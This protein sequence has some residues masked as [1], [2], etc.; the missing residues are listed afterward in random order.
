MVKIF[1]ISVEIMYTSKCRIIQFSKGEFCMQKS[2][3]I[4]KI[5]LKVGIVLALIA[6]IFGM[7]LISSSSRAYASEETTTSIEEVVDTSEHGSTEEIT[8]ATDPTNPIID[9]D[10]TFIEAEPFA[11]NG[12]AGNP[13]QLKSAGNLA[14]LANQ[15]NG[16]NDYEGVYFT[17][18]ANIDLAGKIWTP[19]G[20]NTSNTFR[21][22]FDGDGYTI[23]NLY[24]DYRTITGADA[25]GLFGFLGNRATIK[26]VQVTS[27]NIVSN[28]ESGIIAGY[29]N[30]NGVIIEACYATGTINSTTYM[31]GIVGR[32]NSRS[33]PAISRCYTNVT[34]LGN[35]TKYAIIGYYGDVD[36]CLADAS[37]NLT[38]SNASVSNSIR[39]SGNYLYTNNSTS[40]TQYYNLTSVNYNFKND[41]RTSNPIWYSSS[42]S[43]S[44]LCLRGVGNVYVETESYIATQ[45]YDDSGTNSTTDSSNRP[46]NNSYNANGAY[47]TYA[48]G[49]IRIGSSIEYTK[50]YTLGRPIASARLVPERYAT[51]VSY[52]ISNYNKI[53]TQVTKEVNKI[54][55]S[56]SIRTLNATTITNSSS[57]ASSSRQ[58]YFVIDAVFDNK[59]YQFTLN[60]YDA[61]PN[62]KLGTADCIGAYKQN[63]N[64]TPT[65]YNRLGIT[66]IN[67]QINI[68]NSATTLGSKKLYRRGAATVLQG[69]GGYKYYGTI[70][71]LRYGDTEPYIEV[72]TSDSNIYLA[73]FNDNIYKPNNEVEINLNYSLSYDNKDK[74]LE[75]IPTST[76]VDSNVTVNMYFT[77]ATKL[78]F[79]KGDELSNN[80]VTVNT[81][82][83]YSYWIINNSDKQVYTLKKKTLAGI[84]NCSFSHADL[85]TV[86]YDSLGDRYELLGWADDRTIGLFTDPDANGSY[87]ALDGTVE[88]VFASHSKSRLNAEFVPVKTFVAPGRTG[89]SAGTNHMVLDLYTVFQANNGKL[90]VRF[91]DGTSQITSNSKLTSMGL[92]F[93]VSVDNGANFTSPTKTNGTITL[94]IPYGTALQYRLNYNCGSSDKYES[95]YEYFFGTSNGSY[96]AS[97]TA[98]RTLTPFNTEEY[99][100]FKFSTQPR[101]LDVEIIGEDGEDIAESILSSF[102]FMV[103]NQTTNTTLQT[104]NY[105][106]GSYGGINYSYSTGVNYADILQIIVQ[107]VPEGYHIESVTLANGSDITSN[108]TTYTTGQLK[109]NTK[110]LIT[111]ARNKATINIQQTGFYSNY[112]STSL[113]NYSYVVTR[114]EGGTNSSTL[115]T[116]TTITIKTGDDFSLSSNFDSSTAYFL[117]RVTAESILSSLNATITQ[118]NGYTNS[119][120]DLVVGSDG[121]TITIT[122]SY[123]IKEF[124]L[125]F[126][127]TADS[128]TNSSYWAFSYTIN[129][130]ARN[131][132]ESATLTGEVSPEGSV[133]L[134]HGDTIKVSVN[135]KNSAAVTS[136]GVSANATQSSTSGFTSSVDVSYSSL[137]SGAK[138]VFARVLLNEYDVIFNLSP[139]GST[140]PD[141][142][143]LLNPATWADGASGNTKT[144][145][146]YYNSTLS[147]IPDARRN[148]YNFLGWAT[149]ENAT[150][151]NFNSNTRIL[152]ETNLYPV[153]GKYSY[154]IDYDLNDDEV[155]GVVWATSSTTSIGSGDSYTFPTLT[156]DSHD[157]V[158]WRY[159]YN[160]QEVVAAPGTVITWDFAQNM[161][162]TAVWQR[163]VFDVQVVIYGQYSPDGTTFTYSKI[164]DGTSTDVYYGEL[165]ADAVNLV[166]NKPSAQGYSFVGY[167]LNEPSASTIGDISTTLPDIIV[168][169]N[170][171]TDRVLTV[172]VVYKNFYTLTYTSAGNGDIEIDNY[173][174]PFYATYGEDYEFILTPDAGYL[175]GYFNVT[176]SAY[177]SY[178]SS[179]NV[180]TMPASDLT[181][182]AVFIVA[183][184]D[185]TYLADHDGST[186]AKF[187]DGTLE[188]TGV[189]T[190]LNTNYRY[191]SNTGMPV[192]SRTGYD[193]AGWTDDINWEN[194]PVSQ[195]KIYTETTPWD[196]TE[197]TILYATWE[198]ESYDLIFVLNASG[199]TNPTSL[200]EITV[201]SNGETITRTPTSGTGFVI[202]YGETLILPDL[203]SDSHDLV[204]W[205]I[206]TNTQKIYTPGEQY[207]WNELNGNT[208]TAVWEAK[209]FEVRVEIYGEHLNSDR[210]SYSYV[211]IGNGNTYSNLSFGTFLSNTFGVDALGAP[212]LAINKPT[213]A[214]YTF[215]GYALSVPTTGNIVPTFPEIEL[216]DSN[217]YVNNRV[218]TLYLVYK[219]HYTLSYAPNSSA[220]GSVHVNLS[221]TNIYGSSVEVTVGEGVIIVPTANNGYH[222]VEY[223]ATP[224]VEFL[225]NAIYMPANN[226]SIVAVFEPDII[227]I[228]YYRNDGTE[229]IET[230][231]K[232]TFNARDYTYGVTD[233]SGMPTPVRDGY[234]FVGW[235]DAKENGN[236]YD[237]NTVWDIYNSPAALYAHWSVKQYNITVNIYGEKVDSADKTNLSNYELADVASISISDGDNTAYSE[238]YTYTVSYDFG[239]T[240]TISGVANAGFEFYTAITNST[241][242]TLPYEFV[243]TSSGAIVNLYYSRQDFTL[244]LD[245]NTT[246]NVTGL[247]STQYVLNYGQSLALPTLNRTGYQFLDFDLDSSAEQGEF[248][249]SYVQG[250]E[251][252]TLYAIWKPIDCDITIKFMFENLDGEFKAL[253]LLGNFDLAYNTTNMQTLTEF[254]GKIAYRT[255]VTISNIVIEAGFEIS[256]VSFNSVTLTSVSGAYSFDVP[257]N[258]GDVVIYASRIP[259]DLTLDLN[260]NDSTDVD[261][262]DWHFEDDISETT[263]LFGHTISLPDFT[264]YRDGY[265]FL[266]WS[267]GENTYG[268]GDSYTQGLTT[269]NLTAVWDAKTYYITYD[270][271]T[272]NPYNDNKD[273]VNDAWAGEAGVTSIKSGESYTFPAL[274]SDSHDFLGWTITLDDGTTYNYNVGDTNPIVWGYASDVTLKAKWSTKIFEVKV[275][276]WHANISAS[277]RDNISYTKQA[278]LT[279]Y[280]Q[281][282]YYGDLVRGISDVIYSQTGYSF[283]GYFTQNVSWT[284]SDKFAID[285]PITGDTTI[286][287]LYKNFYELNFSS[288]DP[289]RGSLQARIGIENLVSG[290]YVTYGESVTLTPVP[291]I[292][293]GHTESGY[294]FSSYTITP[295]AR[296]TDNTFTM[297]VGDTNG[298]VSVIVNFRAK[299]INITYNANT[300][301]FSNGNTTSSGTVTYLNTNYTF[302]EVPTKVGHDFIEWNTE[303]DGSG[304][305]YPVGANS[306]VI[307]IPWNEPY[308][309]DT[310]YAI[311]EPTPYTITVQIKTESLSLTED[312]KYEVSQDATFDIRYNGEF[313]T[314]L[315]AF[316][317]DIAYNTEVRIEEVSVDTGFSFSR[318]TLNDRELVAIDGYYLFNV[319][320]G[321]ST[322][323]IYVNRLPYDLTLNADTSDTITNVTGWNF[324]LQDGV[325]K[326]TNTY[327]YKSNIVLP[328]PVREGYQFTGWE[329]V[330]GTTYQGGE[331][332]E[333]TGDVTL[334]ATWQIKTFPVTVVLQAF[335]GTNLDLSVVGFTL[336]DASGPVLASDG[337]ETS[338]TTGR[339]FN[340]G[341]ELTLDVEH[342]S[343][344]IASITGIDSLQAVS[345]QTF[346]VADSENIIVI[347]FAA[348]NNFSIM[349]N[350]SGANSWNFGSESE[351]IWTISEDK[352]SATRPIST[353]EEIN[354]ITPN[355]IGYKFLGWS[356]KLNGSV[357]YTSTTYEPTDSSNTAFSLYAV[358]EVI[359]Y[360]VTIYY[361]HENTSE[362]FK[363]SGKDF[364]VFINGVA[365]T[366]NGGTITGTYNFDTEFVFTLKGLKLPDGFKFKDITIKNLE[367]NSETTVLELPYSFKVPNY[368][369]QIIIRI[370]R[371]VFNVNLNP[372]ANGDSVTGLE[373]QFTAKYGIAKTL[374]IPTRSGY[375]FDGWTLDQVSTTYVKTHTQ[376]LNE[377]TYYAQWTRTEFKL[378]IKLFINR[379]QYTGSDWTIGYEDIYTPTFENGVYTFGI[380]YNTYVQ[381]TVIRNAF[382]LE[383]VVVGTQEFTS[384]NVDFNMPASDTDFNIYLVNENYT[385]T[386]NASNYID[387]NAEVEFSN[388]TGWTVNNE[389]ASKA[390]ISYEEVDLLTPVSTGYDFLGWYTEPYGQGEPIK[391]VTF[392]QDVWENVTYYA[393]WDYGS[394]TL[395]YST[396]LEN[397]HNSEFTQISEGTTEYN[398]VFKSLTFSHEGSVGF[399]TNVTVTFEL[400]DGYRALEGDITGGNS[401]TLIDNGNNTYTYTFNMPSASTEIRLNI[402]R[403]VYTLTFDNG[404]GNEVDIVSNMP[405]PVQLKLDENCT[406]PVT[407]ER[408]GYTFAG[409][410]TELKGQGTGYDNTN[411]L[412]YQGKGDETLYAYWTINDSGLT[413]KKYLDGEPTTSGGTFTVGGQTV[414]P[415][416]AYEYIFNVTYGD[417]L[418]L[419]IDPTIYNLE[420]VVADNAT[421]SGSGNTRYFSVGEDPVTIYIYF[422][423]KDYTLTL[424]ANNYLDSNATVTFNASSGWVAVNSSATYQIKS[425]G[426]VTLITPSSTGYKFLGW[427]SSPNGQGDMLYSDGAEFT[428]NTTENVTLYAKWEIG[429]YSL[430]TNINTQNIIDDEFANN[431][432]G[433]SSLRLEKF[434]DGIWVDATSETSFDYNT[435]LRYI[436]ETKAGFN[437]QANSFDGIS[438]AFSSNGTA[439]IY[440]FTMAGSETTIDVNI[441]R[442]EYVL[443]FANGNRDVTDITSTMPEQITLKFGESVNLPE[444]LTAT[445]YTFEEWNTVANGSGTAYQPLANFTQTSESV[446]LYAVWTINSHK[447]TINITGNA[448]VSEVS[449]VL[450]NS[451]GDEL[452][453]SDRVNSS[454]EVSDIDYNSNLT[455]T[456]DSGIYNIGSVT[457]TNGEGNVRTFTMPDEDVV[458]NIIFGEASYELT[459][460][461]DTTII[462]NYTVTWIEDEIQN[463]QETETNSIK[464]TVVSNQTLQTLPTPSIKGLEFLGWYTEANG[465]G[466]LVTAYTQETAQNVTLYAHY[467]LDSFNFNLNISTEDAILDEYDEN[468]DGVNGEVSLY[469]YDE[470]TKTWLKSDAFT[471]G[472]AVKIEYLKNARFEFTLNSGFEI[473][474]NAISGNIQ[475]VLSN[476]GNTYYYTFI[477]TNEAVSVNINISRIRYTLEFDKNTQDTVTNLPER[478][479]LKMGATYEIPDASTMVRKGYA[480]TGIWNIYGTDGEIITSLEAGDIFTQTSAGNTILF[481][482]WNAKTYTI[483]FD[484]NGGTSSETGREIGYDT[485]IIMPDTEYEGYEL[486]GWTIKVKGSNTT[487]AITTG[488]TLRTLETK[489]S[490]DLVGT[491]DT[492]TFVIT[493]N[494]N[495]GNNFIT[496]SSGLDETLYTQ[497][498]LTIASR[499]T[500]PQI[501][502][503]VNNEL[504]QNYS[505]STGD[506]VRLQA[507]LPE[508]YQVK[509]WQIT[510]TASQTNPDGNLN[511]VEITG[512]T[513]NLSVKLVYEPKEFTVT[514]SASTNGTLSFAQENSGVY[515]ITE[516][517]AKTLSG[518]NVNV[519]AKPNDGF[520]F[521]SVSSDNSA[522]TLSPTKQGDNAEILVVGMLED[523]QISA[524]FTE[525]PNLVLI[526]GDNIAS[527]R[528]QISDSTQFGDN[529]ILYSDNS[530]ITILTGQYLKL[531]ITTNQGYS[532]VNLLCNDNNVVINYPYEQNNNQALI[533]GIIAD[534]T[535][536]IDTE[537]NEYSFEAGIVNNGQEGTIN[538]ETQPNISGK[539][540][541]NTE[542]TLSATSEQVGGLD[543]YNFIGWFTDLEGLNFY[544]AE[545]P[546][547][548]TLT[549]DTTL[550]AKFEIKTYNVTYQ[551]GSSYDGYGT[552]SGNVNQVVNF[553]ES[554]EGVTVEVGLGYEFTRWVI[555]RGEDVS[556]SEDLTLVI[557]NV[558]S[559]VQC[560]AEFN[561]KDVTINLQV[562]IEG[563]IIT[564]G[565]DKVAIQYVSGAEGTDISTAELLEMTLSGKSNTDI[566]IRAIPKQGYTFGTYQPYSVTGNIDVT[567]DG[568][569]I[570]LNAKDEVTNVVIN[571]ARR[572]NIITSSLLISG[573]VGGGLIRYESQGIWQHTG[574]TYEA[575]RN[576]E[577]TLTYKIFISPGYQLE[578]AFKNAYVDGQPYVGTGYTLVITTATDYTGLDEQYF[579]EA[580][581]VTISGY[582]ADVN[583]NIPVE[584]LRTLVTFHNGNLSDTSETFTGEILYGTSQIVG[585]TA[586]QLAPTSETHTFVGWANSSNAILVDANGQLSSTW[587]L[588]ETT[589]DLYAQWQEKL[590]QIEVEVSPSIAL[591]SQTNF[592]TTLFANSASYGLKPE[593]YDYNGTTLYFTRPLSRLYLTLPVYKSGYI[594]EGFYIMNPETGEYEKVAEQTPGTSEDYATSTNCMIN[595]QSFNYYS[596]ADASNNGTIYI[597]LEFNVT[598]KIN[599]RNYYGDNNRVSS[600]GGTVSFVD[601]AG[602][603]DDTA[604]TSADATIKMVATPENGYSFMHWEDET[605]LI[606]SNTPEFETTASQTKNYTAVF[607]G[608][609]IQIVSDYENVDVEGGNP[610]V[611]NDVEYY[612]VGDIVSFRYDGFVVGYDHV[613]WAVLREVEGEFENITT[614]TGTTPS[615]TLTELY[616]TLKINPTFNL[617]TVEVTVIMSGDGEG[618]GTI[619]FAGDLVEY[620][621]VGNTYTFEIPYETNLSFTIVPNIR[622]TF[623]SATIRYGES[624]PV[625]VQVVAN[626]FSIN[627]ADYNNARA[628]TVNINYR[629]IYWREYVL[630]SGQILDNGDGTYSVNP[631]GGDFLGEG[632]EEY[633]YE[634]N[635]ILDLAKLA[636]IINNNIRQTDRQKAEYNTA[637]YELNIDINF[638]DRYWT[639]IGTRDNPFRGTFY[640]R[641]ERT[642]L[643]VDDNDELFPANTCFDTEAE[644][645]SLYGKLFGY[646]DGANIIVEEPSL[647]VLWIV[648][649]VVLLIILI[650][651]IVIIISH[652]RRKRITEERQ[653][654]LK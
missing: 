210:L 80:S 613:G 322:F 158:G 505:V 500:A 11:G 643:F 272:T 221:G 258:G 530:G 192:P 188:K 536:T 430:T 113:P 633:P 392:T 178:I 204:G 209:K 374:P 583:V 314:G 401:G 388:A 418:A 231:G 550:Y 206:G 571:F 329:E 577:T 561:K 566:V 480:F 538:I 454:F 86:N 307:E 355:R 533:Q 552:L 196:K 303:A 464:T 208:L 44:T 77:N 496:I 436:I 626:E 25:Y 611:Y 299:T 593:A 14:Y 195:R 213:E 22:F 333:L 518:V 478:V 7:G 274:T 37:I 568:N 438:G 371:R 115:K 472:N 653:K 524:S 562:S 285:T 391:D 652:E 409:W 294:E 70:A 642:N 531:Q 565:V 9:A 127:A 59:L 270:N 271:N 199:V 172:Y 610:E 169:D 309:D 386:L 640:L 647:L 490:V 420:S 189:V 205:Y 474:D 83:N 224:S 73:E 48:K 236:R 563:E 74:I 87:T 239:K 353:G 45:D 219:N 519:L 449:F 463:W 607:V 485:S 69:T 229:A 419:S 32:G 447:I 291:L 68:T 337:I 102:G 351:T 123:S 347:T 198:P 156:S 330:D 612:H 180:L 108:G 422:T 111:L 326:A 30:A 146:V 618:D 72:N 295:N 49:L 441:Y 339:V 366:T 415:N 433:L 516:N 362:E 304:I 370:E 608:N 493:A 569:M 79:N 331:T 434:A 81:N 71:Y 147:T 491:L 426:S 461:P 521:S 289:N 99:L 2:S 251:A 413:V 12:S 328:T 201:I 119:V 549:E 255:S 523:T 194:I 23:S 476:N 141:G 28:E 38:N 606:V 453:K 456:I 473:A 494:W 512:F 477:M 581:D 133:T 650:I 486:S 190:Y 628:I 163:K 437:L 256:S 202:K 241:S 532:V 18:T 403:Q 124:T 129:R 439:Y 346:N 651:V 155:V 266:G 121:A 340:Y 361:Y 502:F 335:E 372:N 267:D 78:T 301:K 207:V 513:S 252:Q 8:G 140:L 414:E 410:Y 636:F 280:D 481:A 448:P 548:F 396:W 248:T 543:K 184:I 364:E 211:D 384:Y 558:T 1:D 483:E 596:Y 88:R 515:D 232:V 103:R 170:N 629:E 182:E 143:A 648:L 134:R 514:L 214:G 203:D 389:V 4:N 160:G 469:L 398:N 451:E 553:G 645:Y 60:A 376:G 52:E 250:T 623:D 440:E 268:V 446:T 33:S 265:D 417:Y 588:T 644:Y 51:W 559:D 365:D 284:D 348:V 325:Y 238:G 509:E 89:T 387:G 601:T 110:I 635:N 444:A 537:I 254:N 360:D 471:Y 31:G 393:R 161:T 107:T 120:S 296:I 542:I 631:N 171:T 277:N 237:A 136:Y 149:T 93:F 117:S 619:R 646:L 47:K 367:D 511:I 408:S 497:N 84:N 164:A 625:S 281:N 595:I 186:G 17:L 10:L 235:F 142:S 96:D 604:I 311:W 16:G 368:N 64:Y 575:T 605:G 92:T 369:T 455:I 95:R 245:K 627:Y 40:R 352:S 554:S 381:F 416:E 56:T 508:G 380:L 227:D 589:Y 534:T 233:I 506:T 35:G 75:I 395:S 445:G 228:N 153:W 570:T 179:S 24:T 162:F 27:A 3:N 100:D 318:A 429:N 176:P 177:I 290:D 544:T 528:Y 638:A 527:V 435:S 489:N 320:N 288:S 580:Y 200:D 520:T 98:V 394:T 460:N 65:Y 57:F 495:A 555:T 579:T 90:K 41:G 597:K 482:N 263:I 624:E 151:A 168:S 167:L 487:Y 125:N 279:A 282:V 338:F 104:P 144:Y 226:L 467:K 399:K 350:A 181:V 504:R 29:V 215:V 356:T 300:G 354:I 510:G 313:T 67:E 305:S 585:P 615:Y 174:S 54:Q 138:T 36:Y 175:F 62:E 244:T 465:K 223:Q 286:Y 243:L 634:L 323:V 402:R 109:S 427:Y 358:W 378:N 442:N 599:A 259:Y 546:L 639:P 324:T 312:G 220:L 404:L 630:E 34:F 582:K 261:M 345:S 82:S 334:Q 183:E 343:Y 424:V 574:A 492:V 614:L 539:Y 484:F 425:A 431:S 264:D 547:T 479:S 498:G 53:V 560:V 152:Q 336:S 573:N 276:V 193:F 654:L 617:S 529:F 406:L 165:S 540:N 598:T 130:S 128:N 321:D 308:T 46:Y 421:L 407:P 262:D 105:T 273:V 468:L 567:V 278:N 428:Q 317:E 616:E 363:L 247:T 116:P 63:L 383:K 572:S 85:P 586:E 526:E 50:F 297:P 150:S 400:N 545:N 499:P 94:T 385:F 405:D 253:G 541:Y 298:S 412:Y 157:F 556:Y 283:V 148:G 197:A 649:G 315:R 6:S 591:Q 319:P 503:Y 216:L 457:G 26:N 590:I 5:I 602:A 240:I 578:S 522:V 20:Y 260:I 269:N 230:T 126:D 302:K 118:G 470:T 132:S 114:A 173:S 292:L 622:Y 341:T 576:T 525:R 637:V 275:E 397:A 122:L 379:V 332:F 154:D 375:R 97:S 66:V 21:G 359:P 91:F 557:D 43:N 218:L 249:S 101:T 310:L 293:E 39:R 316:E 390:V 58:G 19:I 191:G 603:A 564:T 234:D 507:T 106:T 137:I 139:V 462:S 287:L 342:G 222:F 246:E 488:D 411:N 349:L 551:I 225:D 112:L 475:G 459:L 327:K 257:L 61:S 15:V 357:D 145:T 373:E 42:N 217:S 458:I 592:Y 450:T 13:Y 620:D 432:D 466:T 187:A 535:I 609:R 641:G 131:S 166:L 501:D 242:Q 587:L 423:S 76:Y 382:R 443:S 306:S 632:T 159:T 212:S 135:V 584:R 452:L 55:T 377:V 185:I 621:K 517:T 600:I 344:K 594:F